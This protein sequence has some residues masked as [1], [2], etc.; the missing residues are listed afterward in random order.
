MR[1]YKL[2]SSRLA[3][4]DSMNYHCADKNGT[5]YLCGCAKSFRLNGKIYHPK[6]YGSRFYSKQRIKK[7]MKNT[8]L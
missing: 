3:S 6:N 2:R 8:M 7:W 4:V 5:M 1:G